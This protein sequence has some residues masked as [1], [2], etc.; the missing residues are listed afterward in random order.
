[1][2]YVLARIAVIGQHGRKLPENKIEMRKFCRES[3]GLILKV[4]KFFKECYIR[5]VRTYAMLAVYQFRSQ[6]RRYC[7]KS[8]PKFTQRFLKLAPCIN[9]QV[10]PKEPRC[11][12][13][14]IEKTKVLLDLSN[15]Q[16]K[17]RRTCCNYVEAYGCARA[18]ME[19]ISCLR[20]S[21]DEL[22]EVLNQQSSSNLETLCGEYVHSTQACQRLPPLSL[23]GQS[24][25][26]NKKYITPV[27]LLI[28]LLESMNNFTAPVLGS[29]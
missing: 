21:V 19:S 3:K 17:I 26:R 2:D 29:H 1:M 20:N 15:D 25:N 12:K 10:L 22:F 11:T 16:E 8:G 7:G 5:D 9:K 18:F 23:N 28:D 4:E 13:R 14:F 27:F 24:K 6:M